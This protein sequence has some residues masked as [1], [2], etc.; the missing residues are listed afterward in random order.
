MIGRASK[1]ISIL[2]S[3]GSIGRS[4]LDIVRNHP[5][6]LKVVALAAHNN[7]Q[8]LLK[9]IEE[10]KP[11]MV[12]LYSEEAAEKLR[13]AL[14][15]RSDLE[16]RTGMEGLLEVA[17]LAEGD[18]LLSAMVGSIGLQPVLEAIE[19]GK[20]I[21]L[22]NKETLVVGGELVMAAAQR[23][24][25]PIIPVDSEH[26]AIFQCL[27][28]DDLRFVDRLILTASGGPFRER[29]T[30]TLDTVTPAEALRHPNWE[31]GGKITIDSA[32]LMNKGL[33]VIEAHWL[34]NVDY[35]RISVVVHPQSIVHSMIEFTDG[36]ILAQ[37]GLPDMRLPIQYALS[38]P[39]RWLASCKRTDLT[40]LGM[41]NFEPPRFD[42]FP[43]LKLAYEAGRRGGNLPCLMN[44]A[45]EVAVDSFLKGRLSF[46]AI[47]KVI[48]ETT[49]RLP[50]SK[51]VSLASL[52]AD[53]DSARCE[54]TAM[55]NRGFG[56]EPPPT[57]AA[58]SQ[59][60]GARAL[61]RHAK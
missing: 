22:A 12:A 21:C 50:F 45:N 30:T 19:A 59:K 18:T 10:F 34:F 53:D 31:M 28:E 38:F 39:E 14:G 37:M 6:R 13:Y 26:S 25:I 56:A 55:V 44:A 4:T 8:E 36:S 60:E 42:A 17:S 58:S 23:C 33:E 15:P 40:A 49:A 29:P 57:A 20:K 47:P 9:Q 43:C 27:G 11:L 32:T 7:W 52:L 54:A 5:D 2:G 24:E 48:K 35:D 61:S 51:K 16:L 3:T 46:S 1:K 41:L